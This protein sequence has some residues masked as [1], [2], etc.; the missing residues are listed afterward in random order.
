MTITAIPLL[1]DGSL[2]GH[3][4]RAV[5]IAL[6]NQQ[7]EYLSD[8]A[9]PPQNDEGH[10][11]RNH[12][13]LLQLKQQGVARVVVRRIGQNMLGKLLAAGMRVYQ[14]TGRA[15]PNVLLQ[16][17][18]TELTRAEQGS[19]GPNQRSPKHQGGHCNGDGCHSH[20]H[21]DDHHHEAHQQHAC[22]HS[23]HGEAHG[24]CCSHT[25]RAQLKIGMTRFGR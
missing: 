10:C 4:A 19:V 6:Y 14:A 11:Q 25:Q 18:L 7:G 12:A 20:E 22:C 1:N 5:R 23:A 3:F 21:T 15:M 13:V 17:E 9:L 16:A 24:S 2:S 8:L